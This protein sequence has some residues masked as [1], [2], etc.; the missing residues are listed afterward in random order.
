MTKTTLVD[1]RVGRLDH[2][3]GQSQN[4]DHTSRQEG[5]QARSLLRTVTKQK[6]H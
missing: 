6:P 2:G 3:L 1:R 4:K 5:R